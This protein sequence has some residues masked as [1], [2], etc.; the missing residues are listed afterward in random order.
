LPGPVGGNPQVESYDEDTYTSKA[1]DTF[2]T[3]SQAVYHSEQYEHALQLFNRN[4]PLAGPGLRQDPPALQA[5]QPVYIPPVRIL[6]KYYGAPQLELPPRPPSG[7]PPSRGSE[8]SDAAGTAQPANL[9]LVGF[10]TPIK[11]LPS[12]DRTPLYRVQDGGELM[13]EVA[14][15]T[16]G[17]GDRWTEIY[18]LNPRF[19]PKEI[20]PAGSTLQLPRD[21]HITPQDVP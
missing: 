14:R 7:A 2:R 17:N 5:G 21:A 13:R 9:S 20:L 3:I 8:R 1:N 16:L 15:R 11:S 6:E 18:R 12:P 10:G 19:D 4:H